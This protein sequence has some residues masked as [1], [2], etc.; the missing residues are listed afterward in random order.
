MASV[1]ARLPTGTD[2]LSEVGLSAG[3]GVYQHLAGSVVTLCANLQ[4]DLMKKSKSGLAS[5]I[6]MHV[7][8]IHVYVSWVRA[9]I[10]PDSPKPETWS[11]SGQRPT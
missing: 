1:F 4:Q 10:I 3:A 11:Q 8:P 2:K 9:D 6:K 5:R 7:P